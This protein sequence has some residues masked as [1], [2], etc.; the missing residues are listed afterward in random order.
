[1]GFL[2]KFSLA[3]LISCVIACL[4]LFVSWQNLEV[5]RVNISV[6]I[7]QMISDALNQYNEACKVRVTNKLKIDESYY[8]PYLKNT[9]ENILNAYDSACGFYLEKKL[10]IFST[11][12]RSS[13]RERRR[14][15]II[16]IVESEH[17]KELLLDK[18]RSPYKNIWKVYNE[19]NR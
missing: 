16:N 19:F 4:L 14:K 18:D 8:R 6:L 5:Q 3:D 9:L 1:M 12:N 10:M 17:L 2:L 13:F 7:D 15:E 11:I